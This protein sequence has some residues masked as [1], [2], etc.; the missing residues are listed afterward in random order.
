MAEFEFKI[1]CRDIDTSD[2]SFLDRL[3]EAG[4]DDAL[5]FFKDGY[6]CMDFSRVSKGA[7]QAVWSAIRDIERAGIGGTVERVEPDDLASLSEIA[8]RT[9]VT[10]AS[11]QKYARGCSKVGEDFP[12]PAANISG[13]RRELYSAAEVIVW[14]QAKKRVALPA[15]VVELA[16]V[17]AQTNQ[18]LLVARAQQ[19]GDIVRLV[20]QL[21][22]KEKVTGNQL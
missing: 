20:G 19:D 11:L 12:Q 17:I 3:F 22:R 2:D 5:V 18:A 10:R 13:S 14:M 16:K 15:N 7:E 6:V 21:N 4:C 1:F 9:G 8:R